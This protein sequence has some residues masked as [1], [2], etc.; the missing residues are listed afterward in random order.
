M[1]KLSSLSIAKRL[2]VLT[3]CAVLGII[4]STAVFLV[5][6]RSFVMDERKAGVGRSVEAVYGILTQ[7]QEEVAM[8]RMSEPDAQWRAMATIKALRYSG[9]EY[10]WIQDMQATMKMHPIKPELD[11]KD[12]SDVK[13]PSGLKLFVEFVNV[14]KAA[15]A[16]G[17]GY[18]FYLWPKPGSE[19]PVQKV[20]YVKGFA[21]WGWILGSGIY[22]DT[23]DE[24]LA[25]RF[26]AFTVSSLTLA[27]ALLAIGVLIAR[28]ILKQ[29]GGEPAY[30]A[31]VTG[32]IAEGDL[33]VDIVMKNKESASLLSA[34]G[35]MRDRFATIVGQVRQ[36][37]E[38]VALASAE[39]AQGNH[40]LSARTES[41]AS[42]LQQA[43]ASMAE[44]SETVK[45]NADNAGQ[46]NQLAMSASTVAI[47][48]GEVV[49]QV[50][51]TMKGINDSSRKIAD[52]ISVIDGIAFQ[53]NILALNA[54]VEA[55][56]AGEQ[57]RGFAVGVRRSNQ[58]DCFN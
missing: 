13:D 41:Q 49:G 47:K 28:S 43:T 58:S 18:V 21:P 20:S 8:G 5:S 52:I 57:G 30:A 10:F 24:V 31:S 37:S 6:E 14:V 53:T 9:N 36:G 34:I 23:V 17:S 55:A 12:L 40:D 25:S 44:L 50:V 11:G 26:L 32:R 15:G 22:V 48:G 39:I 54:A 56:R 42:A 16:N 35:A 7:F 27:L 45:R 1:I 2:T 29:L 51:E 3:V 33:L 46:A 38:S 19:K 4:I